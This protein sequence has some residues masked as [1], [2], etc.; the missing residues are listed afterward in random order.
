MTGLSSFGA[1]I[2]LGLIATGTWPPDGAPP[3]RGIPTSRGLAVILIAFCMGAAV[4]GTVVGLLAIFVAGP[5]AQP[6]YG[7]LAAGPALA[8]GVVGLI[9]VARQLD[10]GDPY[11]LTFAAVYILGIGSLG[12][13]VA[14]MAVF[15]V[16]RATKSIAD[17]PFVILGLVSGGAAIAI[18]ATGATAVTAMRG[19][20]EQTARAIS[21]AQ[22]QRTFVFQLAF[23]AA[24]TVAILLIVLS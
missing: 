10:H 12:V 22:I 17:W 14:L 1:A 9:L 4:L 8:G 15:V 19:A 20:D 21:K 6:G 18:G 2:A 3:K 16:E 7:L 5:V 11:V 23:I 13:A 24:S